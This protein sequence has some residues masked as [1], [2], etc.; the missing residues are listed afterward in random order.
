M[1]CPY[2]TSRLYVAY[3]TNGGTD[4]TGP[5]R[6]SSFWYGKHRYVLTVPAPYRYGKHIPCAYRTD[7]KDMSLPYQHG[8]WYG[9]HIPV[10]TVPY[11]ESVPVMVACGEAICTVDRLPPLT[12]KWAGVKVDNR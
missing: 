1:A 10:L 9:K 11:V 6:T 12:D 8:G 7:H 2:R 4:S 5:Y 3:R